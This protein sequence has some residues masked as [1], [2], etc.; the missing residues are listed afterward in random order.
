MGYKQCQ[1]CEESLAYRIQKASHL[2]LWL[3]LHALGP[4]TVDCSQKTLFRRGDP[5]RGLYMVEEGTV[6]LLLAPQVSGSPEFETVGAGAVL[7][8]AETM[9]GG[10]YKLTAEAADRARISHIDRTSL[11]D[12]LQQNHQLCL[13]IVQLLSE[14]LH[15]LYR[16]FLSMLPVSGPSAK[17]S[18]DLPH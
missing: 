4:S 16:R 8:L 3:A 12:R 11:M 10:Q 13:Q 15:N 17:P 6:R 14:D 9:T 7:G 2:N 1:G 18:P 5:C